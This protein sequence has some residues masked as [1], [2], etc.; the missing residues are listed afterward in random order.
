[1]NPMYSFT[2]LS[3]VEMESDT[4]PQSEFTHTTIVTLDLKSVLNLDLNLDTQTQ[5]PKVNFAISDH[6]Y[7]SKEIKL[8][9]AKRKCLL[10][11]PNNILPNSIGFMSDLDTS[12]ILAE[13]HAVQQETQC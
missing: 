2:I 7:T 4:L 5:N 6:V 13:I 12:M 10:N 3:T 9:L 1:M 11:P 8:N